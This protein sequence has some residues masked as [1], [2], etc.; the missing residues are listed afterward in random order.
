M[1]KRKPF[2]VF[3]QFG[4]RSLIQLGYT[5]SAGI[6]KNKKYTKHERTRHPE[7]NIF[8]LLLKSK[9]KN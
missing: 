8:V 1:S 4:I 6:N 5:N 9:S 7:S 3:Q 2:E